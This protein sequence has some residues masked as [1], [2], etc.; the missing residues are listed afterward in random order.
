MR[1]WFDGEQHRLFVQLDATTVPR[2]G[3]AKLAIHLAYA[4]TIPAFIA[5]SRYKLRKQRQYT[6]SDHHAR[7]DIS[8]G[9]SVLGITWLQ[10]NR[11]C[12]AACVRV[13]PRPNA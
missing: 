1:A 12:N 9:R 11:P 5:R 13:L 6:S 10:L 3:R 4:A 2:S 7:N 8:H